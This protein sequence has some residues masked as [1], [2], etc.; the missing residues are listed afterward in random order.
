MPVYPGA[1][2]CAGKCRLASIPYRM[3]MC[4]RELR[5]RLCRRSY[6]SVHASKAIALLGF[7]VAAAQDRSEGVG[8]NVGEILDEIPD[9][10]GSS[11]RSSSPASSAPAD[12]APEGRRRKAAGL[13]HRQGRTASSQK[14]ASKLSAAPYRLVNSEYTNSGRDS[15]ENP[16]SEYSDR[17]ITA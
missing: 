9:P 10:A 8:F 4:R 16:H 1:R 7:G 14:P 11:A 5:A 3:G 15:R 6:R 2:C 17:T 12:V 13:V